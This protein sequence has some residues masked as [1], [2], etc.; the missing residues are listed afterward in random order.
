MPPVEY[1]WEIRERAKELYVVDGLT[2]EEVAA[3]LP[4]YFPAPT[5]SVT[6]LKRWSAEEGEWEIPGETGK[7]P[8]KG[9]AWP[10]AR[11]EFRLALSTIRRDSVLLRAKLIG[12]ALGKPDFKE[13]LSAAMWEKTQ[14]TKT[15]REAPVPATTGMPATEP[16]GTGA[17]V[18]KTPQEVVAGLEE[19]LANHLQGMLTG[20]KS[21]DL[22]ALKDFKACLALVEELKTKYRPDAGEGPAPEE[23]DETRRRLVAEVNRILGV[24]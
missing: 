6:Q 17:I 15:Q 18:I 11:K 19:V 12:N 14:Q 21:I 7:E 24:K 13:V 22:K 3:A 8:Q 1:S 16:I 10:E 9:K 4:D 2:F 20:L 5:P 23:T